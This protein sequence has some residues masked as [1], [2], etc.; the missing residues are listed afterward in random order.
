[1]IANRL[2]ASH[3]A[4]TLDRLNIMLTES[5][6]LARGQSLKLDFLWA[7]LCLIGVFYFIFRHLPRFN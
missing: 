1:M 5:T 7:G 6:L 4:M 3:L 2:V